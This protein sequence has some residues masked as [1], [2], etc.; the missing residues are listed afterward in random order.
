M[1]LKEKDTEQDNVVPWFVV[2]AR[3]SIEELHS[4]ISLIADE[5]IARNDAAPIKRLWI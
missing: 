3:K 4:E 2:D 1:Y 5:I